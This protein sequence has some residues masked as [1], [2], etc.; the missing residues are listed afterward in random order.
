MLSLVPFIV[1]VE[2]DKDEAFK[3]ELTVVTLLR[4][5]LEESTYKIV[6]LVLSET[7]RRVVKYG[8]NESAFKAKSVSVI[9]S[10]LDKRAAKLNDMYI[11]LF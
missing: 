6:F 5:I 8:L 11:L 1:N 2:D 7:V 3:V 10:K 9:V 4:I